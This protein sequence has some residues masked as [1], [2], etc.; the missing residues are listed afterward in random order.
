MSIKYQKRLIVFTRYPVQ[1]ATKTRLIP[2]L[3]EKG[4]ADLQ[5]KM[6]EHTVAQV[7]SLAAGQE[8]IVEIRHDGGSNLL[9]QDWLGPNFVYYP[10]G[11]GGLG[12]RMMRAFEDAFLQG[13]DVTVMVGTDI[14]DLSPA[15]L[16]K[17][18]AVLQQKDLVLGPA[19][20]GGYYLIGL[21]RDVQSRYVTEL[22]SG[23]T[24]GSGDVL[25]KT[26][27]IARRRGM[28]FSLL[29]EL[30]DVDRPEDLFIW[31]RRSDSDCPAMGDKVISVIIPAV[32]EADQIVKTLSSIGKGKNVEIIVVDGGSSDDTVVLAKNMNAR[33]IDGAPPRA[34]QMNQGAAEATGDI[35]LFL[36]ADTQL[37]EAF[38]KHV[39]A[40]L[41]QPGV[42]AGAFELGIDSD[43]PALRF[44]EHLA[45][46]RSRYLKTPYGDQAIFVS[47]KRFHQA[48]GFL[49]IP[50]MEDFELIR[51]LFKEGKIITLPLSVCTSP[52][53]W[54]NI[55]I[56]R[57]TLINQAV[58]AAYY[59]G[60]SL[61]VIA[62]WY[63][64]SR[65]VPRKDR[66]IQWL[67]KSK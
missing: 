29:Q 47:S 55:G 32:N 53:R 15:I 5:R 58:I 24:W 19:Q 50:I 3:G 61:D 63:R 67:T 36:H 60:I 16:E 27:D 57:T 7:L 11:R 30:T 2:S 64:R 26:L 12:V 23:I 43:L 41:E 33:V 40:A 9:M 52:R 17:A 20:D 66:D 56:L 22:F 39:V 37:P 44:L 54:K 46:F 38:E 35:L 42:I 4:A 62:R 14:P 34:R 48:G 28:Q 18:F 49:D 59:M 21:R 10:Q 65:Q 1:G 45:N 13:A 6:V 8:L 25:E 31:D 51:R